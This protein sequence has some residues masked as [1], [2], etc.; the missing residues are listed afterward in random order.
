M[1]LTEL[2]KKRE[3]LI[4]LKS[5]RL[6][7]DAAIAVHSLIYTFNDKL[8]VADSTIS[9]GFFTEADLER[10]LV[11]AGGDAKEDEAVAYYRCGE[12]EFYV[13][14]E[15]NCWAVKRKEIIDKPHLSILKKKAD[16]VDKLLGKF[17]KER[18]TFD[19]TTQEIL[20]AYSVAATGASDWGKQSLICGAFK[21]ALHIMGL[22]VDADQ[23]AKGM[24][25]T[26]ALASWEFGLAA[27]G[28]A[29]VLH[30]IE[31]DA[32]RLKS[33]GLKLR[34]C[35]ITDHG[36]RKGVD[37]LVKVIMWATQD[38]KNG[39]RSIRRF[40]LDIDEAG[41]KAEE[42]CAAIEKSLRILGVGVREVDFEIAV[43]SGD[44][45]GGG[46]VQTIHPLLVNRGV[47]DELSTFLTCMLHALQKALETA[48]H[49]TLGK[50]G[51]NHNTCFQLCYQAVMLLV[52]IKKQGGLVLCSKITT[53][54][55]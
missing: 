17:K 53:A 51:M 52:A 44:R 39:K 8:G 41:H 37:H 26:G 7:E 11:A 19:E 12:R 16:G 40:N 49:D 25:S 36:N 6:S 13:N 14:A 55:S 10:G 28:M 48:S 38:A 5:N 50:Q 21:A 35:L 3:R 45:G 47:M 34:I 2:V 33:K 1:G 43:I 9:Y 46:A 29:S 24:P 15:Y 30:A 27:G 20:S 22:E 32:Q 18:C 42:V 54:R 31:L 4:S 23:L